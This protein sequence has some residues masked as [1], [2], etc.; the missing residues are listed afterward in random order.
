LG[1]AIQF[2]RYAPVI[3][4]LGAKVILECQDELLGIM[5]TVQGVAQLIGRG[6][7]LPEF[8]WHCPLM[9]APWAMRTRLET[10]PG[11]VPYLQADVG[12]VEDWSNRLGGSAGFRVGLCWAGRPIHKDDRRRSIPLA[13]LAPLAEVSGIEFHSLQTGLAAEQLSSAGW[14]VIDH[15]TL[16]SH[17]G[18]T[19]A[20][21]ANLDLVISVDTSVAHLAGALGKPTWLLLAF[22][23]DWRWMLEREDSPWYPTMKLFRQEVRGNWRGAV[24]RVARALEQAAARSG[25]DLSRG[26]P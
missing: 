21:I 16:L 11:S 19:A 17:F 18:E 7:A 8:D 24:S 6:G 26:L 5:G 23:P 1:D 3:A 13:E 9:S 14:P 22:V 15:A 2:A 12:R 20:L 10:I 25:A 4:A